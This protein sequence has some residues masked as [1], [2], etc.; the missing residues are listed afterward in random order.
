MTIIINLAILTIELAVIAAA[1]WVAFTSS[2]GFGALTAALI[3]LVGYGL[4]RD[5]LRHDVPFYLSQPG[6]ASRWRAIALG[7]L[8][9]AEAIGR[10]LLAGAVAILTFSGKDSERLLLLTIL[11]GAVTFF[12]SSLLR[13]LS[14][15]FAA[16]PARWGY[17]RLAVPLGVMF[18]LAI[19]ASVGIGLLKLNSLSEIAR[20][21][22]FDLPERPDLGELTDI[23]FNIKQ[24]L[25]ALVFAFLERLTGPTYAKAISVIVSLNVLGGLVI[26]IYAV[27]VTEIVRRLE[28]TWLP[29]TT[30]SEPPTR[31][32]RP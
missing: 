20:M 19:Q 10:A 25:D 8:A 31:P 3:L 27:V 28:D 16:R 26:S 15:T 23:M 1:A 17:F 24:T 14:R 12:G 32:A 5:R 6:T 29:R 21:I 13:R 4:E 2:I 22:V 9:A 7:L 18:S 30:V 11:F